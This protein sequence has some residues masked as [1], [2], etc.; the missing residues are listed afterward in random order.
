VRLVIQLQVY[1]VPLG[2]HVVYPNGLYTSRVIRL[3]RG[4][5]P[6]LTW[7]IGPTGRMQRKNFVSRCGDFD[8]TCHNKKIKC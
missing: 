7:L 2:T 3:W 8:L 6:N 4:F 5:S 1:D